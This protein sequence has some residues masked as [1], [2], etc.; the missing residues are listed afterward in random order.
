MQGSSLIYT[1]QHVLTS[2]APIIAIAAVL[3]ALLALVYA[4]LLERRMSRLMMG[5]SGSLEENIAVISRELK[6]SV[7][8]R[9]EVE[10]YLKLVEARLRGSVSGVGVVRFNPFSND[11]QGGN[12]SFS[13]AFLDEEGRG[14]VFST[15][16][17]RN[18]V[19]VYAKPLVAW[20]STHELS[21]EE[22]RAI[23]EA[24]QTILARKKT[25]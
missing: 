15:L 12:Q 16:Y 21:A 24:R 3:L 22:K 1:A 5:R 9:G 10:R 19:G 17:A 18:H 25:N 7:E 23:D 6:E 14:V 11:V 2:A 8:F 20:S 13:V 4:T